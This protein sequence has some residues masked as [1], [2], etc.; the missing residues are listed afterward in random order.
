M[1]DD[2][3]G[4]TSQQFHV[5]E[6]QVTHGPNEER[7]CYYQCTVKGG[8][9]SRPIDVCMLAHACVAM[10]A[11]EL[12]I[13]SIDHDGQN[14]GFNLELMQMVQSYQLGIP[15]IAS[16]GAGSAQDFVEVFR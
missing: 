16:S 13:N 3:V 15:V 12:L 11:G 10:G 1:S 2:K 7:H 8:R 9:E 5:I 14:A 4:P 6:S